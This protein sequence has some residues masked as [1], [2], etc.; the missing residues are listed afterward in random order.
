MVGYDRILEALQREADNRL[1]LADTL[2]LHYDLL[3]AQ[4]RV[5]VSPRRLTLSAAEVTAR[6][7]QGCPLLSPEAI[8]LRPDTFAGLCRQIGFITA[9]HRPELAQSLARIHAWLKEN[10]SR[11]NTLAAEYLR[12]GRSREGEEAGLNN[13]LLAFVLNNALRPFLRALAEAIEVWFDDSGWYRG[14][15]PLCGGEPDCAGLEKESGARRLLCSRCDMEWHYK[16]V[17]CPFC[18]EETDMAYYPSDDQVYR[19]YVCQAC[20][21]YLKTVDQRELA[22]PRPLPVERILTMGMD[23]T[24]RQAGFRVM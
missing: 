4:A 15:C 13:D 3:E 17:G 23:V 10:K 8:E 2:A 24:A 16:R 11:C 20:R 14:Y 21:R 1:D 5:Q 19:L 6:L 9:E 7:E 18:G 22:Q 12:E